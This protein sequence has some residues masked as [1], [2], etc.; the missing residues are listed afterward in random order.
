MHLREAAPVKMSYVLLISRV[1]HQIVTH[2]DNF[3]DKY[4]LCVIS[5]L[6]VL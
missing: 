4:R 2:T 1:Y 6:S 3:Q 5:V